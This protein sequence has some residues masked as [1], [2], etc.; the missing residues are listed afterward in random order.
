MYSSFKQHLESVVKD[1]GLY[2]SERVIEGNV[3]KY[4]SG[5]IAASH[6]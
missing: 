6:I 4:N 2:K 3:F 1:N 5:R